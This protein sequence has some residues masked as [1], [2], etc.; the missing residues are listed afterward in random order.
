MFIHYLWSPDSGNARGNTFPL[1][2]IEGGAVKF[3]WMKNE[4]S[5]IHNRSVML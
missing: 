4:E 1:L 3:A 2:M 5:L